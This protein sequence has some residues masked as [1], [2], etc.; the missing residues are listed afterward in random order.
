MFKVM[1]ETLCLSLADSFPFLVIMVENSKS[2]A[3]FLVS[4]GK[5][6][7]FAASSSREYAL[8]GYKFLVRGRGMVASI[9]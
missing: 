7:S 5:E 6:F 9:F 2:R 3:F 1:Q 4:I 8:L